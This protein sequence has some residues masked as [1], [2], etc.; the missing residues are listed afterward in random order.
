MHGD[1]PDA[2]P[3]EW[4]RVTWKQM[5]DALAELDGHASGYVDWLEATASLALHACP[6]IADAPPKAFAAA[7]A[8]LAAA[9]ADGDGAVTRGE[10]EGCA[11]WFEARRPRP[12][13]EADLEGENAIVAGE[14]VAGLDWHQPGMKELLWDMFSEVCTALS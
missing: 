12:G 8:A 6:Q 10:W 11:L 14:E 4:Q 13:C 1:A 7:A 3:P 9:D 2:F 5:H